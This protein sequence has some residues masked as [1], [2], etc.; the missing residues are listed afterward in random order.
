MIVD[1]DPGCGGYCSDGS[2]RC[3]RVKGGLRQGIVGATGNG[4]PP[5]GT[6]GQ[7]RAEC[8]DQEQYPG[9]ASEASIC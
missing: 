3:K 7:E 8:R 4:G 5:T 9:A 6:A 1:F 2:G